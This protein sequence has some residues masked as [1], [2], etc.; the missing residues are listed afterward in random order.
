MFILIA[1]A[2]AAAAATAVGTSASAPMHVVLVVCDDLGYA[3]LGYTGSLIATPV[4]DSLAS[5][6]LVSRW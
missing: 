5:N 4:I 3:D 6:G 1:A 2:A